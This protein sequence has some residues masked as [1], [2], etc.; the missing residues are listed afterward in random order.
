MSTLRYIFYGGVEGAYQ[1]QDLSDLSFLDPIYGANVG[2][3]QEG[4][5][6]T[7]YLSLSGDALAIANGFPRGTEFELP[8]TTPGLDFFFE[9]PRVGD[10]TEADILANVSLAIGGA[11]EP[12]PSLRVRVFD[13]ADGPNVLI[14]ASGADISDDNDAI[15]RADGLWLP[16]DVKPLVLSGTNGSD[17]LRGTAQYNFLS[18]G[19]G[20]DT[21]FLKTGQGWIWGGNGSDSIKGGDKGD[22]LFGGYG[23][24]KILG[25]GGDDVIRGGDGK[26]DLRGEQGADTVDGGTGN[27]SVK[28]GSGD[29]VLGGHSGHD[30]MYG[31]D[32]ADTIRGGLGNDSIDGG[33]G[34]DWI[35][36]G[37]GNDTLKGGPGDDLFLFSSGD[38]GGKDRVKDF[39]P[40]HDS[41]TIENDLFETFEQM[42]DGYTAQVGDNVVITYAL[43][44][45]ITLED[46][47]ISQ[48]R[49]DDF[50]FSPN[51]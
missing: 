42:L 39:R 30:K 33:S 16:E 51:G 50:G 47:R 27:D 41:I 29:D 46:L 3:Y 10:Y 15:A 5:L 34:N 9:Q 38:A 24:D 11:G 23:S 2:G 28:G 45:T 48:L 4:Q 20:G 12:L 21:L 18:G 17:T 1:N 8:G 7:G 6:I 31:N 32:G 49:A 35:Y 22:Y 19:G 25:R 43:G 13:G 40:G 14:T 44:F 36:D 26:D 37:G